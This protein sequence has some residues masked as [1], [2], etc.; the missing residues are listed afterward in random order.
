[1]PT[2]STR[3][4]RTMGT[5]TDPKQCPAGEIQTR[6][7]GFQTQEG[8]GRSGCNSVW[9]RSSPRYLQDLVSFPETLA[10][11]RAPLLHTRHEDAHVVPTSQPQPDALGLHEVHDPGISA[12]PANEGSR[13]QPD[14]DMPGTAQGV[15]GPVTPTLCQSSSLSPPAPPHHLSQTYL[16]LRAPR[17]LGLVWGPWQPSPSTA[18]SRSAGKESWSRRRRWLRRC[19]DSRG[20]GRA[21]AALPG[22][23]GQQR[24]PGTRSSPG[25]I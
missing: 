4:V 17:A 24:H 13:G 25:P 1:M 7:D 6:G 15:T 19:Q 21:G 8:W 5:T 11:S 18:S 23:F 22:G 14:S 16:S 2:E 3:W 20:T 12:V 10:V 9:S